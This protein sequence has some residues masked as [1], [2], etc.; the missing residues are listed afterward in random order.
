MKDEPHADPPVAWNP[1]TPKGVST[2]ALSSF[3]RVLWV[4]AAFAVLGAAVV[5]WVIYLAWVPM[6]T[7]AIRQLPEHGE[8]R[9]GRLDFGGDA[10]VRLAENRFLAVAVDLDHS[11][12][13]RSPANLGLEFGRNDLRVLSWLGYVQ[14]SYPRDTIAPFNRTDLVPWWG[15]WDRR[16][17]P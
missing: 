5:V 6:I 4:Q 8:I 10:P 2:F 14:A 15:A 13:A 17:W 11:G 1:L 12:E 7:S 16:F 9:A 3:A